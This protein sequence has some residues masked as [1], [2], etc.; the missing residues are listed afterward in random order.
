MNFIKEEYAN[1]NI[2]KQEQT[3]NQP[4][5]A[6]AATAI[7]ILTK[8]FKYKSPTST[9]KERKDI[10]QKNVLTTKVLN[11]IHKTIGNQK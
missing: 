1:T 2:K 7:K 9:K 6:N 4:S 10:I 8:N 5:L 11:S 3:L